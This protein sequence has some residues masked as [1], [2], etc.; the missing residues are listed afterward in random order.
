MLIDSGA[1]D[2][3]CPVDFAVNV[4]L[5]PPGRS[6]VGVTADGTPLPSYGFREVK[7]CTQR[8][9]R[10]CVKFQVMDIA[11]PILSVSRLS[12]AGFI[13]HIQE[14]L[15]YI[16]P[17]HG[18]WA[19]PLV[20]HGQLYYLPVQLADGSETG[21]TF[22]Q[23]V[24][25]CAENENFVGSSS[26]LC[27]L[28]CSYMFQG[29]NCEG[30]CAQFLGHFGTPWA[31]VCD[32]AEHDAR[33][34]IDTKPLSQHQHPGTHQGVVCGTTFGADLAHALHCHEARPGPQGVQVCPSENG[35]EEQQE[36][37]NDCRPDCVVEPQMPSSMQMEEHDRTHLPFA[38]WCPTCIAAKAA[39]DAHRRQL[40]DDDEI[41]VLQLDYCFV[42]G[43]PVLV[44]VENRFGYGMVRAVK[45]KGRCDQD[46]FNA[47]L[48]FF[49][50]AG[51]NTEVALRIR[52]DQEN[53]IQAVAQAIARLR[54][55]PTV[56]EVAPR[57]SHSSLAAAE[58][59]ISSLT[60]QI[61]ALAIDV[62]RTC[63]F[64]LTANTRLF[65]YAVIHA[66]WLLA[67]FQPRAGK[68]P[69]PFSGLQKHEYTGQ[70]FRF[71]QTVILKLID[72]DDKLE[73]KWIGGV[74][75]GKVGD[76][77]EHC[78]WIVHGLNVGRSAKVVAKDLLPQ[79]HLSAIL[80]QPQEVPTSNEHVIPLV[81]PSVKLGSDSDARYPSGLR[82]FHAAVGTTAGC[83]AYKR[84]GGRIHTAACNHCRQIWQQQQQQSQPQTSQM[85]A[86][87][88]ADEPL[89]QATATRQRVTG[90]QA[91]VL[92]AP[93]VP[94]LPL[95]RR[96]FGKR[97]EH[98]V[99]QQSG[100]RARDPSVDEFFEQ[101]EQLA[102]G[103][104]CLSSSSAMDTS[105]VD[106]LDKRGPL[107]YS[108]RDGGVFDH[109]K[110]LKGMAK[111][112]VSHDSF[113][114]HEDVKR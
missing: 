94:A 82:K 5:T 24:S 20:K 109:E 91:E 89:E 17:A 10:I 65:E 74:W 52:T 103:G 39:D 92:H 45:S 84:P 6:V 85:F 58:Q 75:L 76:S 98:Q 66:S 72:V 23:S 108:D 34:H 16:E 99:M 3:V 105:A 97:S 2:H 50:E 14:E 27:G 62:Q 22:Q 43:H 111:E 11:R 100:K 46:F 59:Y 90:K 4:P 8:G 26:R 104:S 95:K 96:I 15:A 29:T 106:L 42:Q 102:R 33:S 13:T 87:R 28:P 79:D 35:P 57:G 93:S 61:R 77:D 1:F 78:I 88:T 48:R 12:K 31:C 54:Q 47:A 68:G 7:C 18:G 41:P 81:R 114:A 37:G 64:T 30:R 9:Q 80:Q 86:K 36:A 83:R 25:S 113:Q 69:T 67:R 19:V 112:L 55:A 60:G 56:V 101:E 32:R 107:W 73:P 44:A 63:N 53:S 21:F 49:C 51:L 110:V 40:K 70:I 38:R 71:G